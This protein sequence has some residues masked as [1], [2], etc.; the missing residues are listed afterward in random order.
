MTTPF[1]LS[2]GGRRLREPRKLLGL[3][4]L[5]RNCEARDPQ[6]RVFVLVGLV[7]GAEAEGL[8]ADYIQVIS[9]VFTWITKYLAKKLGV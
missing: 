6:D 8:V 2:V 1:L 4:R 5:S 9:E 3:L 7:I